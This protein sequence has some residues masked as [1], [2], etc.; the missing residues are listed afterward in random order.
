M[1]DNLYGLSAQSRAILDSYQQWARLAYDS[2]KR[3]ASFDASNHQ[4]GNVLQETY[5]RDEL[6]DILSGHTAV[7]LHSLDTRMEQFTASSASLLLAVLRDADRQRT[8]IEIDA[9]D[10]LSS[11]PAAAAAV[12]SAGTSGAAAAAAM[13]QSGGGLLL[14]EHGRQLL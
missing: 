10:V 7:L 8:T 2:L 3:S 1:G 13:G 11:S 6:K 14:E 12:A 5:T 4:V 9:N